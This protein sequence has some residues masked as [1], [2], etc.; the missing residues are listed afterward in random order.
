M[1]KTS[2]KDGIQK[3]LR[4]QRDDSVIV[5]IELVDNKSINQGEIYS[6]TLSNKYFQ[7]IEDFGFSV[8]YDQFGK[9]WPSEKEGYVSISHSKNWL[10]LSYSTVHLQGIDIEQRRIQLLKI[11]PRI[12]HPDELEFLNSL[13][14]QQSALQ[15]FWGAKEALYKAYGRKALEFKTNLRI[16]AFNELEPGTFEGS[17]ILPEGIKTF[18]L[19]WLKPD[20][21]SWLVFVR[22]ETTLLK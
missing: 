1:T 17:I 7:S 2:I 13:T 20:E 5:G 10:F 22:N 18:I 21:D 11:A 16:H 3:F 14:D 9:P 19:E 8:K 15:V 12:L 6:R 4:I